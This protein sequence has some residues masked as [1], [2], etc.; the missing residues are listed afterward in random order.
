MCKGDTV[1]QKQEETVERINA[2]LGQLTKPH[3]PDCPETDIPWIVFLL[4]KKAYAIDARYIQR[5][6]ILYELVPFVTAPA[7][8][9]GAAW[10]RDG[11]VRL[12]DLRALSGQGDYLSAMANEKYGLPMLN[13]VGLDGIRRG[14]IVDE[15][16]AITSLSAD[17]DAL[18]D[19]D[20]VLPYA[21]ERLRCDALK[22]PVFMLD[23]EDFNGLE[24]EQYDAELDWKGRV[25]MRLIV[26]KQNI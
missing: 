23:I 22:A 19:R 5:V 12:L 16:I 18:M 15:F 25:D 14:V 2:A 20:E 3:K 7:Y 8:C 4:G 6:A 11:M 1:I 17:T 26:N 9:P 13:V 21:K 10:D 24:F